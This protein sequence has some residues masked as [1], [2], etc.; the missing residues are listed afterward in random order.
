Q[1]PRPPEWRPEARVRRFSIRRSYRTRP[2]DSRSSCSVALQI[3]EGK[4]NRKTLTAPV[5]SEGRKCFLEG[6]FSIAFRW[7]SRGFRDTSCPDRLPEPTLS[8]RRLLE[9]R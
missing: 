8:G 7:P 6:R 9:F 1:E 4:Q 3:C 5:C 2:S